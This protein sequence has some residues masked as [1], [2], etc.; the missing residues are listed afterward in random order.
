MAEKVAKTVVHI[1]T[2]FNL[3]I[4]RYLL[5]RWVMTIYIAFSYIESDTFRDW[6]LYIAPALKP[7]LVRSGRIIQRW[8]LWEFEKQRNY[9]KK[10]LVTA[11]SRIYI[12]F[13]L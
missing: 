11:R 13:N 8:I 4:F 9:I 7:Y 3:H 12:S 1:I 2:R 5:I 6:V 10:Q